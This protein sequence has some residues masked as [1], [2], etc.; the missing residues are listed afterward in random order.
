MNGIILVDGD[1]MTLGINVGTRLV[2]LD[3]TFDGSNDVKLEV[4]L[5]GDSLVSN[6]GKVL[7][8]ILGNVY[9]SKLGIDVGTELGS[10]DGSYD[11]SN[12]G[13]LGGLYLGG[14]LGSTDG[15]TLALY[16]KM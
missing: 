13:K 2:S 11:G 3:G 9:G 8:I 12:Y 5:L 14:S 1:V 4:L 6:D 10:L 16:L 15:N 7:G